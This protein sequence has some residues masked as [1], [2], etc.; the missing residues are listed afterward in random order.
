MSFSYYSPDTVQT[1]QVPSTQ[2]N[3]PMLFLPTDNRFR[4]I[5]NGGHVQSASGY[6]VRPFSDSGLSSSITFEL[7]PG[8]FNATTGFFEMWRLLSSLSDGLVTYTGYGDASL[9]T[10]G[11]STATWPSQYKCVFHFPDG[12]TLSVANSSQ[13][14][15]S[16]TNHGVTASAGQIDGGATGGATKWIDLGTVAGLNINA[17]LTM[18]AWVK[19][20][21]TGTE[22]LIDGYNTASPNQ[23]YGLGIGVNAAGKIDIYGGGAAGWKGANSI[24]NSGSWTYVVA[25]TVGN[26]GI[27]F[28]K[29]ALA[30]GTPTFSTARSLNWSGTRSLFDNTPGS[31]APWTQSADEI[32]IQSGTTTANWI[33][34][35]YNNQSAPGTF[36]VL[37]TEVAV[38]GGALS[39]F[40]ISQLAG[41]GAGG[42]FFQNPLN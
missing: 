34:T 27:N 41:L 28:Y 13:T 2:T 37:G 10:D 31:V 8:T 39:L 16:P 22:A 40:R 20:T 25:Q 12:M 30:D 42:P 1:G 7:V 29:N 18:S 35:E 33:T 4:T 14:S 17:D 11:S 32:H 3:F 19:T 21:T 38:G 36:S 6:D 15:I 9:T 24:V 26:T 5:A 23:G